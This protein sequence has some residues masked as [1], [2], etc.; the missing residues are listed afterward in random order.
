MSSA[1]KEVDNVKLKKNNLLVTEFDV[2][3]ENERRKR[4]RIE[5]VRK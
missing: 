5:Q 2:K 1:L 3:L 4:M